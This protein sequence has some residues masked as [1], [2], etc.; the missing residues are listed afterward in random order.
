M[1]GELEIRS[2]GA[3]VVDTDTLRSTAARFIAAHVEL[4]II[5]S[6]LR[7][8][9]SILFAES[10]SA[11]KAT[12]ATSVLSTRLAT[13]MQ[14]AET[15][16][17]QLRQ[18]AAV[19]E[20]VELDAQHAIAVAAGDAGEIAR[21]DARRSHLEGEFAGIGVEAAILRFE[22]AIMWPSELVRIA[23]ETGS[24]LGGLRSDPASVIGGVIGGLSTIGAAAVIGGTRWGLISPGDRLAPRTDGVTL[25]PIGARTAT[26]APAGLAAATARIPTGGDARVRVERYSMGDGSK[27]FVVYVAGTE[28]SVGTPEAWDVGSFVDLAAGRE[29]AS[30]QATTAALEAAGAQP[31]DVVHAVG[32]SQGA[33]ITSHL[34]VEGGYDTRTL[35]SV[36]SPVEADVGPTTLSVSIRHTDDPVAMAAGGGHMAPVGAPGS[37]IVEQAPEGTRPDPHALSGYSATAGQVDASSDPRLGALRSTFDELG[38]ATSVDAFEYGASRTD[39]ISSAPS[40]PAAGGGS[41][42]PS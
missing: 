42:R 23:T 40:S 30:Y 37:L 28:M 31:G 11:W 24:E 6:R 29:S 17:H 8:A 14:D 27:Q 26:T 38:T 32:H 9:Q 7:S 3:I 15:I 20:L 5:S 19:Y 39:S 35:V 13:V 2:G 33:M 21:I 36:G 12:S 10:D 34:A 16:A 4:E 25:H 41:R 18:A 22:R 1:S